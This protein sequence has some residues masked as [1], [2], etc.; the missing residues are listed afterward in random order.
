M[1]PCSLGELIFFPLCTCHDN[2]DYLDYFLV[3]DNSSLY[4]LR[5]YVAYFFP[6]YIVFSFHAMV[7]LD[8][9]FI[10]QVEEF[11]RKY[12]EAGAGAR[13]RKQALDRIQQNIYWMTNF[14]PVVTKWLRHKG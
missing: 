12:P 7:S 1:H 13:G 10:S 2:S 9:F 14:K 8:F 5:I 6:S 3:S 4:S 11:F